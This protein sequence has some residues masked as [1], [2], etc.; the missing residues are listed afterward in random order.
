MTAQV[1]PLGIYDNIAAV[2]GSY[3]TW[4]EIAQAGD[5]HFNPV[6]VQLMHPDYP[7]L[8][9]QVFASMQANDLAAAEQHLAGLRKLKLIPDAYAVLRDDTREPLGVVGSRY[10]PIG[11]ADGFRLVDKIIGQMEGGHYVAAGAID[12]GSR[13]WGLADLRQ[14]THIRGTDDRTDHYLLFSTSHDGSSSWEVR[15][16]SNRIWCGNALN[17][18][19]STRAR[20]SFKIRHT[21]SAPDK[22]AAAHTILQDYLGMVV[23]YDELMNHLARCSLGKTDEE[24]ANRTMHFLFEV[25]KVSAAQRKDPESISTKTKNKINLVL[26]NM[27]DCDGGKATAT[28][29]TAYG[30]LHSYTRYVDNQRPARES[31]GR[32]AQQTRAQ[33][34]TFGSFDQTKQSALNL[35]KE[36]AGDMSPHQIPERK[37]FDMLSP[38][39]EI[40]QAI[41]A[42]EE[43]PK[44]D[45]PPWSSDQSVLFSMVDFGDE[46][47]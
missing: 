3:M 6:K 31:G 16:T 8:A 17:Y 21:R 35:I 36:M 39:G 41:E 15:G 11:H 27:D 13:V 43:K 45:S 47:D 19:L 5:L 23:E 7:V 37:V 22:I 24:R 14:S 40:V 18:E 12:Q 2:G 1:Q 38:E 26:G 28:A 44:N 25:F 42:M 9:N 30:L 46:N 4:E 34:S 10:E 20:N 33:S 32:T 29:H